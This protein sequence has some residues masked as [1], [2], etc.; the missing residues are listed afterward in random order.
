[1]KRLLLIPLLC[2]LASIGFGQNIIK[3]YRVGDQV[4][5]RGTSISGTFAPGDIAVTAAGS[6]INVRVGGY[7]FPY[8]VANFQ[9]AD[10]S[11]WGTTV[12]TALANYEAAIPASG[13]G[14]GGNVTITTTTGTDFNTPATTAGTIAAGAYF[15]SVFNNGTTSGTLMGQPLAAQTGF[16]FPAIPG[17]KHGAI[18][19]DPGAG[20]TFLI[21][22]TR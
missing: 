1:M 2:L 16:T 21:I 4:G 9:K 7:S 18:T 11:A 17:I 10:G 15:V 13:G 8:E 19:Y 22:G 5:V 6:S 3:L 14:G 12:A 20:N